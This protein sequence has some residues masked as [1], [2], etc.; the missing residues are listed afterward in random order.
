MKKRKAVLLIF[1]LMI[2]AIP[3]AV[4]GWLAK[5]GLFTKI[6]EET[7]ICS[8]LEKYSFPPDLTQIDENASFMVE[9]CCIYPF[10]STNDNEF[11][12]NVRGG[13]YELFIQIRKPSG[14]NCKIKVAGGALETESRKLNFPMEKFDSEKYPAMEVFNLTEEIHLDYNAEK[15]FK[16]KIKLDVIEEGG[17]ISRRSIEYNFTAKRKTIPSSVV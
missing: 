16:L 11:D 5:I 12:G 7:Y 6:Y 17:N 9:G 1:L 4:L 8:E 15:K 14:N 2:F 13:P 3:L 10:L